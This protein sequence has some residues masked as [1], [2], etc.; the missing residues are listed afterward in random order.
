ELAYQIGD[1][2][3][4][5]TESVM[6]LLTARGQ[7]KR[8]ARSTSYTTVQAVDNNPLKFAPSARDALRI[9]FGPATASYLDARRAFGQS[10][11]DLK[12]HEIRTYS[13]MQYA[14]SKLLADLD[15]QAIDQGTEEERGIAAFVTSRKAKLWDSYV[16]RWQAKAEA[17][18]G[19]LASAFMLHFSECYDR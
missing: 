11:N 8:M 17:K 6:Q 12:T 13:A 15:P 10:F 2:L 3:Q 7:A 1:V 14:L 19:G 4:L 5:V 9:M 18:S 16:A